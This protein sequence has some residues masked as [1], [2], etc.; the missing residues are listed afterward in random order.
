MAFENGVQRPYF[1]VYDDYC[2]PHCDASVLHAP[3]ECDSCD[4]FPIYQLA[5]ERWGI[6]FTR[7][8]FSVPVPAGQVQCP[9]EQRR[10]QGVAAWHGNVAQKDGYAAEIAQQIVVCVHPDEIEEAVDRLRAWKR[11]LEDETFGQAASPVGHAAS[12]PR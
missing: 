2:G 12:V 7:T 10:G 6:A 8:D 5:R 3:G 11:E 9:A 1:P 4:E